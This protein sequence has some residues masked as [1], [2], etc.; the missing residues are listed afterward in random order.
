MSVSQPP[1]PRH[2]RDQ[3]TISQTTPRRVV[4][5]APRITGLDAVFDIAPTLVEATRR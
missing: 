1:R 3:R 2:N 4:R 5:H